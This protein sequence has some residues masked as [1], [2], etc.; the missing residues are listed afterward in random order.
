[1]L[2]FLSLVERFLCVFDSSH[3][4]YLDNSMSAKWRFK[5]LHSSLNALSGGWHHQHIFSVNFILNLSKSPKF[6]SALNGLYTNKSS[7]TST[8]EVDKAEM[9][10]QKDVTNYQFKTLVF[11]QFW[12]RANSYEKV[13]ITCHKASSGQI[14]KSFSKQMI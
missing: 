11:F 10:S 7:E 3:S 1:M 6:F 12:C 2:Y 5:F 13:K 14:L 8:Q 9:N 4:K